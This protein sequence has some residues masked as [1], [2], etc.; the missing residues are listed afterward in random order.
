MTDSKPRL[1]NRRKALRDLTGL[2]AIAGMLPLLGRFTDEQSPMSLIPAAFAQGAPGVSGGQGSVAFILGAKT[3]A[4]QMAEWEPKASDSGA[5]VGRFRIAQGEQPVSRAPADASRYSA[6]AYD[7]PG[8]SLRVLTWKKGTPVV[9]QITYETEIMVLEGT[10]TLTPPYGIAGPTATLKKGDALF[11]PSGTLR[12]MKTSTDTVLL[13]AFVASTSD[14][15]KGAIVYGKDV[16]ETLTANWMENGKP[17]AA[18]NAKEAA[19]APKNAARFTVKRYAFDGNSIRWAKL[20]K[21]GTT[22]TVT[23][24]R[25]DVLIYIAKGRMRRTEG[26]ETMEVVAGDTVREIKDNPGHWEIL[27]DSEF[28][29]TDAPIRANGYTAFVA[30]GGGMKL[31][32]MIN[33]QNGRSTYGFAEV[34]MKK[35]SDTESVSEKQPG[36]HWR[37]GPRKTITPYTRTHKAYRSA[38]GPYEQHV[39][40]APHFTGCMAGNVE[41]TAQDGLVLRRNAGDFCFITPGALHHSSFR[42]E[43]EAVYFNLYVPGTDKDTAALKVK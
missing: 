31:M 39:G 10:V 2:G 26:N 27:E 37:I 5:E 35:V 21:G 24:G 6:K 16:K 1:T 42:S 25:T 8:G 40:G 36:L 19:K 23:T 29:A 3:E 17:M 38:T 20:V 13:Q 30:A 41:T 32:T 12:N 9:H 43:V 28:L 7:F 34:P 15:P 18:N 22:N 4:V 14:K 11:M 33:D